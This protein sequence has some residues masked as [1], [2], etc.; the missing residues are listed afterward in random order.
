MKYL[1]IIKELGGVKKHTSQMIDANPRAI[2]QSVEQVLTPMGFN[3]LGRGS[4][5]TVWTHPNYDYVLKVFDNNDEG[6]KAWVTACIQHSH[7]PHLPR[8][9]SKRVWPLNQLYSA[10]RM[11]RLEPADE[12]AIYGLASDVKDVVFTLRRNLRLSMKHY[13][14]LVDYCEKHPEFM[15]AVEILAA[16]VKSNPAFYPDVTSPGNIMQRGSDLVLSDPI[17]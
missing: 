8:F 11:E 16:V 3:Q 1:E 13:Q 4:F 7:N 15:E 9:V 12:R 17:S 6:Y 2:G 10:V 14:D 5:A